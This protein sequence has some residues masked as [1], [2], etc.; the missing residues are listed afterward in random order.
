M[1]KPMT[2]E[3]ILAQHPKGKEYGHLVK[4]RFPV[5]LDGAGQVVSLP[6]IINAQATAV[7][8]ATRDLLLD[9]TGTDAR[10]VRATIALLATCFAEA[11][12]AIEAVSVKDAAG[13]W[14]SPDLKGR[15]WTLHLDD[16]A[17]LLGSDPGADAAAAALQRMG[18]D[19]QPF[20]NK[21]LVHTAAWRFDLLH[22]VDVIEEVAIGLGFDRIAAARPTTLT[23]AKALPTQAVEERVRT[24]MLGL[25]WTEAKTLTLS[26][27]RDEAAAWGAP[28]VRAATI[29][30][31]VLEEQTLLRT[32]IVP[33]LLRVL[34]QNRHRPLP[35][36]LWEAGHV[37]EP[38][39]WRNRLRLAAVEVG[40][41]SDFA[42]A[43][44][45]AEAILRDT[46]IQGS[47]APGKEPGLIAGRQGSIVRDGKPVGWF[48]ELHPDT[49]VAF[50]LGA[51]TVAL[52]MQLDA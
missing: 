2:P 50:G 1:D 42:G 36:R 35:Q 39:T 11:G 40:S 52:E 6:P 13:A 20:G 29:L 21:L 8:A 28:P 9:V 47:L 19:A 12:G 30:N 7:T 14:T 10:A 27:P 25:G 24:V 26:N 32:R 5:F 3:A 48:G 44:A 38:G 23:H 18:H 43:K 49:V 46:G 31:P 33:S 37:V 45:L 4:G 34:A 22:P 41:R 17:A 51:A 15:E 16:V